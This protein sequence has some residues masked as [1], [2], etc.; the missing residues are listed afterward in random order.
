MARIKNL[1]RNKHEGKIVVSEGIIGEI[2]SIAVSEM[3]YVQFSSAIKHD[4]YNTNSVKVRVEKDGVYVDV[5]VIIHYTQSV[6]ETA[7]KIQEVVRHNVEAMTEYHIAG[8]NVVVKGVSF[9]DT[10]AETKQDSS[11]K[12]EEKQADVEKQSEPKTANNDIKEEVK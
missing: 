10:P 11:V 9:D 1:V 12:T 6:S 2:V 4:D 7:F 8:V 5:Y 3:P